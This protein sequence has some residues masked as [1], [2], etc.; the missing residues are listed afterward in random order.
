MKSFLKR[1]REWQKQH[2]EWELFCDIKDP[3]YLYETFGELPAKARMHWV[4]KYRDRAVDAWREFGHPRCKV[5]RK[6]LTDSMDLVE[7]AQWPTGNAMTVYRTNAPR[8]DRQTRGAA[9]E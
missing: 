3:S 4:G 2:P 1:A 8:E 9:H 5:E 7:I 6:V